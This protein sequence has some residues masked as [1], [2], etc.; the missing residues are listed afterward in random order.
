MVRD[1]VALG[2]KGLLYLGN[3]CFQELVVCLQRRVGFD[4]QL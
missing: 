2:R 4:G 3:R 1:R